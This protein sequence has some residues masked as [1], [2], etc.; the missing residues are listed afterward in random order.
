MNARTLLIVALLLAVAGGVLYYTG[1]IPGDAPDAKE[2]IET[3]DKAAKQLKKT[4]VVQVARAG[5]RRFARNLGLSAPVEAYNSAI[6]TPKVSATV[7]VIY[8]EKGD[9]VDAGEKLAKL[10]DTDYRIALTSAEAQK[11]VADAGVLQARAGFETARSNFERF[12]KLLAQN[13]VSQSDFDQVRTAFEQAKAAVAMAEAQQSAAAAGLR[14]ARL[15]MRDT[16]VKAPFAGYVVERFKDTG[17]MASP[18]TPLFTVMYTDKLRIDVD[19]TEMEQQYMKPGL[20]AT[21]TLDALPKMKITG[22]VERVNAM[23]SQATKS[24]MVRL[25]FDN[26][27]H[28][29]KPGM[30]ARIGFALPEQTFLTVPR[31]A[32]QTRDNETGIAYKLTD[33]N[34]V[35]PVNVVMGGSRQGYSLILSGLEEQDR[36]ILAGGVRFEDGQTVQPVAQDDIP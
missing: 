11:T 29:I 4:P 10:D 22:T 12:E 26:P 16:V 32:V 15:Q 20:T 13:T 34:T 17:E 19:V 14:N 21:V 24:V 36:V 30:T 5:Y 1:V 31:A 25:V 23:V 35:T 2:V 18:Q 28:V 7:E 3:A 8:H 27:D 6:L 9:K 33:K